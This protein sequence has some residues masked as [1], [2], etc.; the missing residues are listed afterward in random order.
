MKKIKKETIKANKEIKQI[1]SPL[2][3]LREKLKIKSIARF[4]TEFNVNPVSAH[5]FEAGFKKGKFGEIFPC[6]E[7]DSLC[8]KL[9][10]EEN[11]KKIKKVW[12]TFTLEKFLAEQKEFVDALFKLDPVFQASKAILEN[13]EPSYLMKKEEQ[14]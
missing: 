14:K 2:T 6:P 8:L 1:K 11:L 3:K 4:A 13:L 5:N 12:K 10:E 7:S 9:L